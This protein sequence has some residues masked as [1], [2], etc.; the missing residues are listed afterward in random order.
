MSAIKNEM[1]ILARPVGTLERVGKWCRNNP[2]LQN[3]FKQNLPGDSLTTQQDQL[4][5]HRILSWLSTIDDW[6]QPC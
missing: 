2:Q 3:R 1:P 6:T 5:V 4:V